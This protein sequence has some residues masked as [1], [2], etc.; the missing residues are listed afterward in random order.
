[1]ELAS[2]HQLF[3]GGE[4]SSRSHGPWP[5]HVVFSPAGCLDMVTSHRHIVCMQRLYR[6]G[7]VASSHRTVT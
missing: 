5:V 7:R 6:H 4:T 3:I 2:L 1:M